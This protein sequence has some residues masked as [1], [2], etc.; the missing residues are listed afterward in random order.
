[1]ET[2]HLTGITEQEGLFFATLD[3]IGRW[4]EERERRGGKRGA[5]ARAD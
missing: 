5:R 2:Q 4:I 1:M 3:R